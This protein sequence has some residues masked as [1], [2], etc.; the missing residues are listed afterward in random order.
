MRQAERAALLGGRGTE[1]NAA[2][3]S[4]EMA[5]D[6]PTTSIRTRCVDGKVEQGAGNAGKQE[7]RKEAQRIGSPR[8]LDC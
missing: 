2:P 6:A 5:P 4:P 1:R 8:D 7:E 3:I